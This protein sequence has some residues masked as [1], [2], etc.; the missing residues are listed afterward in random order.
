LIQRLEQV[1]GRPVLLADQPVL[2]GHLEAVV[3]GRA[4]SV[5][6]RPLDALVR[7]ERAQ[8][9]GDD[10]I[11]ERAHLLPDAVVVTSDRGLRARVPRSVPVSVL[12]EWL[13]TQAVPAGD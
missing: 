1:A 7:I 9:A 12:H 13:D 4:R 2:V 5:P 11:S 10:L 8:G 6:D 3:E